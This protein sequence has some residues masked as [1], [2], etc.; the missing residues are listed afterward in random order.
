MDIIRTEKESG[1]QATRASQ[2]EIVNGS[3]GSALTSALIGT[4]GFFPIFTDPLVVLNT[5]WQIIYANPAAEQFFRKQS[6]HLLGY[7]AWEQWPEVLREHVEQDHRR[8]L[9]ERAAIALEE[10][11]FLESRRWMQLRAVECEFGIVIY[12]RDTTLERR[13]S[14]LQERLA[15]IVQSSDDAIISKDLSGTITSWNRGAEKLFG[16]TAEEIVGKHISTLAAPDVVDEIPTILEKIRRGERVDHYE[17]RRKTKDGRILTVSLTVSP[18][19]DASGAVIGASKVG[20]DITE[21]EIHEKALREANAALTQSNED[22]QQF[23]YSASHDLQ[24]PLRMVLAYG[25]MLKKKFGGVLDAKGEEYLSF[26]LEGATRME[27]L[28]SDL[29]AYTRASTADK[30]PRQLID[31]DVVL[32]KTLGSIDSLIKESGAVITQTHLPQ[33]RIHEFQ[34]EQLFQ[35]LISNAIRYCSRETPLINVR[36]EKQGHEWLFSIQDNGIGIDPQYKE[37]IFGLFKRLHTTSEYPGTGMGLAICQRIV[38]R[39][40]GRIWVESELGKGSTIFFTL[41]A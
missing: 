23:A 15:A 10:P 14:G 8:A 17:T 6:D 39:A 21:R 35:N 32:K 25:E 20:R 16:Y 26:V 19:R 22:L 1:F 41:P 3:T 38:Q 31:A 12:Y 13:F 24:E 37:Q 34:L 5:A 2:T 4:Q 27:Q 18:I 40:G 9:S 7:R 11:N 29:R 28:L 36:A 33:I 30:E